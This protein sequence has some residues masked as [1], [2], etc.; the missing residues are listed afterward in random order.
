MAIGNPSRPVLFYSICAK[1]YYSAYSPR[2]MEVHKLLHDLKKE[3]LC[4]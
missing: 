2:V 1:C 4:L 3:T